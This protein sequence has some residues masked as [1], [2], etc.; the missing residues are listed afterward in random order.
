[1]LSLKIIFATTGFWNDVA[2]DNCKSLATALKNI[3][4]LNLAGFKYIDKI[5][6]DNAMLTHVFTC[7][8]WRG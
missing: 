4:S 3:A 1:M 8:G 7:G 2:L 5:L 6:E